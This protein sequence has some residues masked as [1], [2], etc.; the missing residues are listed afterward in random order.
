MSVF[1][2]KQFEVDQTACAMK[3]NT[4]GV[5]IGALADGVNANQILD[6]GTGTGVIALMIAQRFPETKV[7]AVEIDR[8][9]A[10]TSAK[11]FANSKFA[12]R[13][14]VFHG[15]FASINRDEYDL[16]VSNPPFFIDSLKSAKETKI[17]ARHTDGSFFE[18]LICF[19][20]NKLS[21][22]GKCQMILPL[23]TSQLIKQMLP[24][25][26]LHLQGIIHIKSFREDIPH[27]EIISFGKVESK[28]HESGLVI[29][30]AP[31]VYSAQYAALLKNF[32]TIF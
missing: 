24:A 27:R 9:A 22:K 23:A 6:I 12:E 8:Q 30:D 25:N 4:D 5:L 7:D 21:D 15:D 14:R 11:N 19:T 28:I 26:A 18:R 16:I 31:K 3:V 29:Y 17:L 32:L 10:E 20:A 2:F 13:L 1:R